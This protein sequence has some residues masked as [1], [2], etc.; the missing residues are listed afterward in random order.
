HELVEQEEPRGGG[1]R[2]RELQALL[3]DQRELRR[4]TVRLALEADERE[5]TLG[6]RRG[7]GRLAAGAPVE[8]PDAHVVEGREPGERPHELERPR[9]A[10]GAHTVGRPAAISRS[11]RRIAPPSGTR[12]P[13]IR[14]KSVVLP[15]PLGPMTPISSPSARNFTGPMTVVVSVAAMASRI[16]SRSSEPALPIAAARICTHA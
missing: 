1:E 14:L 5:Q 11:R 6:L 3:V 12:A 2:A 13:V 7:R 9:D 8:T 10:L 16:R 4:E 15:D